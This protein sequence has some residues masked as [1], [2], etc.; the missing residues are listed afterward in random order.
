MGDGCV[1][2]CWGFFGWWCIGGFICLVLVW[3]WYVFF[4]ILVVCVVGFL[5]NGLGGWWLLCMV[6]GCWVCS[7]VLW[8]CFWCWCW[9]ILVFVLSWW[10]R[11]WCCCCFCVWLGK[12]SFFWLVCICGDWILVF[13]WGFWFWFCLCFWSGVMVGFLLYCCF[14]VWWCLGISDIWWSCWLVWCWRYR[15]C[16]FIGNVCGCWLWFFCRWMI[17]LDFF[18]DCRVCVVGSVVWLVLCSGNF[19]IGGSFVIWW[20]VGFWNDFL[21]FLGLVGWWSF[22]G[23]RILDWWLLWM[24]Y[25]LCR[26]C[27]R[28]IVLVWCWVNWVICSSWWWWCWL[29][30]YWIGCIWWCR[31]VCIGWI[32]L[33]WV[34]FWNCLVGFVWKCWEFWF[35]CFCGSW[36]GWL[37]VVGCVRLILVFGNWDDGEFCLFVCWVWCWFWWLFGWLLFFLLVCC[38]FVVWVIFRWRWR[39]CVWWCCRFYC[40]G[41]GGFWW[42]CCWECCICCFGFGFVVWYWCLCICF[43]G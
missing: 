19:W 1:F 11:M 13:W 27:W 7:L 8:F 25:G 6:I 18:L 33:F 38:C 29:V 36:C 26:L 35:W 34:S 28:C 37:V 4:M 3:G 40:L 9:R 41:L 23:W 22:L 15:W 5:G 2:W 31:C 16:C 39:C 24:V 10:R 42:W 32:V 12:W 21:G 17:W 30:G 20:I 43:F 14:V